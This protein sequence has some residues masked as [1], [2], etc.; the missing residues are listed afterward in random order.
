[1]NNTNVIKCNLFFKKIMNYGVK[2]LRD[3]HS[4]I[5]LCLLYIPKRSD[6]VI[7]CSDNKKRTNIIEVYLIYCINTNR[8][9]NEVEH[10]CWNVNGKNTKYTVNK[11]IKDKY[12]NLDKLNDGCVGGIHYFDIYFSN[13][14][15][16]FNLSDEIKYKI[17][18]IITSWQMFLLSDS[19]ENIN[20]IDLLYKLHETITILYKKI[21]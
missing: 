13:I 20:N 4:Y 21:E 10:I 1:M 19:F 12:F 18:N 3:K 7:I 16:Y 17:F 8:Y 9:I 2:L 11:H 6:I 5:Y 15:I 14:F